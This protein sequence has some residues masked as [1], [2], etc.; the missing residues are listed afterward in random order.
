MS[1]VNHRVSFVF[2]LFLVNFRTLGA[3][4]VFGAGEGLPDYPTQ[5]IVRVTEA[6]DCQTEAWS[7]RRISKSFLATMTPDRRETLCSERQAQGIPIRKPTPPSFPVQARTDSRNP[8]AIIEPIWLDARGHVLPFQTHDQ[9]L[10]FLSKAAVLSLKPLGQ[11]TTG[12]ERAELEKDGVQLRAIFRHVDTGN[13]RRQRVVRRGVT[14]TDD[15]DSYTFEVAA[16]HLGRLIG[17]ETIP[18]VVLQEIDGKRGSLQFWIENAITEWERISRGLTVPDPER[19]MKQDQTMRL[20]DGLIFNYDRNLGNI[21]YDSTWRMWYIDHTRSFQ[22]ATRVPAMNEIVRCDRRIWERLRNLSD[23]EIVDCLDP[24]LDALSIRSLLSRKRL[25]ARH[26]Q[27]LIETHGEEHVL[28]DVGE[29]R[30]AMSRI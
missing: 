15:R 6:M 29:K 10:D 8:P 1:V 18:P 25:L 22:H 30:V 12:A 11:G 19:W 9:I 2:I 14:C 13:T 5:W 28:F 17:I 27:Y 23:K 3:S 24:F 20:F 21:L 26:I 7:A 4:R 16:Y